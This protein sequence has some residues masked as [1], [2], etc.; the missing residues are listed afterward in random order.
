M[1]TFGGNQ[2][3][4]NIYTVINKTCAALMPHKLHE[5]TFRSAKDHVQPPAALDSF[6]PY[7][8]NILI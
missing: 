4:L 5:R 1:V 3:D 7:G 8:K 6:L 2:L